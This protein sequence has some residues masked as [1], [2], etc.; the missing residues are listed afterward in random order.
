MLIVTSGGRDEHT[1]P[2]KIYLYV[3]KC[4][5][6]MRKILKFRGSLGSGQT[7]SLNLEQTRSI[8]VGTVKNW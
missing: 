7:K 3:E 6:P 1:I 4:T 2:T 5:I 8:A